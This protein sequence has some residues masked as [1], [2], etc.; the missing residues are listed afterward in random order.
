M[1]REEAGFFA[2]LCVLNT[3]AG[4]AS[5]FHSSPGLITCPQ[6]FLSLP[7]RSVPLRTLLW[8]LL[9][10]P[11][12]AGSV[13]HLRW[14]EAASSSKPTRKDLCQ[15]AW[16]QCCQH[17]KSAHWYFPC[18]FGVLSTAS[19]CF[20]LHGVKWAE[21]TLRCVSCLS[22]LCCWHKPRKAFLCVL[23]SIFLPF[24]WPSPVCSPGSASSHEAGKMKG[25]SGS[26]CLHTPPSSLQ[27]Y[28]QTLNTG[29]FANQTKCLCS[30][31]RS[32]KALI[33]SQQ[34][35]QQCCRAPRL[36]RAT[37]QSWIWDTLITHQ[38]RETVSPLWSLLLTNVCH[39]KLYRQKLTL[40]E[41]KCFCSF[42]TPYRAEHWA[43]RQPLC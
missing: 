43:G 33:M 29:A 10:V 14:C 18:Q 23:P 22:P 19:Y 3:D 21:Q 13:G 39:D 17:W 8:S 15:T 12:C 4:N 16:F 28:L 36:E 35:G 26:W 11:A 34:E 2:F 1:E 5:S 27:Q 41:G 9:F 32:D 31:T 25:V 40:W 42:K 30:C 7:L 37:G 20:R 24:L 38:G 6:L